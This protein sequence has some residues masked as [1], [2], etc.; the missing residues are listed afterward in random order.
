MKDLTVDR[1][2]D[3]RLVVSPRESALV[4]GRDIVLF[5]TRGNVSYSCKDRLHVAKYC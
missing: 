3:L 1:E 4:I 2:G 5:A